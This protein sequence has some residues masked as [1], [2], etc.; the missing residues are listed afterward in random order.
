MAMVKKCSAQVNVRLGVLDATIADAIVR[1]A[2]EVLAGKHA[3]NFMLVR[4][5]AHAVRREWWLLTRASTRTLR[6]RRRSRRD[7]EL[8]PT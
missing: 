8:R 3:D 2:D 6:C 7:R 1:A 5:P 4:E